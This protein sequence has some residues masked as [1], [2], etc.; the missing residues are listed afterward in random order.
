MKKKEQKAI[1]KEQKKATKKNLVVQLTSAINTVATDLGTD[2]K[3]AKIIAKSVKQLADKLAKFKPADLAASEPTGITVDAPVLKE[4]TK[5]KLT[6]KLAKNGVE[7][8]V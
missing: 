1:V 7:Q 6:T 3:V 8:P 4:T 2:K 5:K